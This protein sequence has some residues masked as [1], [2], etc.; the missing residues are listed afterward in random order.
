LDTETGLYFNR[1]RYYDPINGRFVSEDPIR[2]GGG[3]NFYAYARNNSV[4]LADQMGL[5]PPHQCVA[6]LRFRSVLGTTWNHA[7]WQV[8]DRQGQTLTIDGGPSGPF[9]EFLDDWI[10]PGTIGYYQEDNSWAAL[11]FKAGPSFDICD[12]I[13]MLVSKAKAWRNDTFDY[14]LFGFNSNSFARIVGNAG[15]FYPS[16]PP[17]TPAWGG[18]LP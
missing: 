13:D 14:I 2:S 18:G 9:G 17:N 8:T 11:W 12:Q 3:I 1:A 16:Q 15:G 6:E 10:K 4:L 7:F 5:C